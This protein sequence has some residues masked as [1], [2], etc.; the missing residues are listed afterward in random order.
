MFEKSII[1]FAQKE[2]QNM[3]DNES[4]LITII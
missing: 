3:K 4:K 1:K 2:N